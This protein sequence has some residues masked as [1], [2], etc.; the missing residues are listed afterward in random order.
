[1]KTLPYDVSRCAARY[2]A[3]PDSEWCPQRDTCQRYLAL[4]QWDKQAGMPEYQRIP[5]VM[6]QKDCGIK[7][8]VLEVAV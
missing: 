4:T 6:G 2:N 8:E 7:I 3:N 5:V 1:M